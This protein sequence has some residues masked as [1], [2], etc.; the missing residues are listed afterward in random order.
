MGLPIN[1]YAF[2][3]SISKQKDQDWFNFGF[4]L[5][6]YLIHSPKLAPDFDEELQKSFHKLNLITGDDFLFT[7]FVDPPKAWLDWMDSKE[8]AKQHFTDK[9][10][11]GF[12]NKEQIKNPKLILKTLDTSLSALLIAEE[13]G[14]N[15][16]NLP[17]LI[18]TTHPKET[19][20]YLLHLKK[21]TL[22]FLM[23]DLTELAATI[24]LGVP[25]DAAILDL[26]IPLKKIVLGVPL[27]KKF[28]ALGLRLLSISRNRK[29]LN[30]L[31]VRFSEERINDSQLFLEDSMAQE[32]KLLFEGY[33]LVKNHL[34]SAVYKTN[35]IRAGATADFDDLLVA[36][37]FDFGQEEI[38]EFKKYTEA[39][40]FAFLVQ[41]AKLK[42]IYSDFF[43]DAGPFVL[44]FGKA[45]E[46][47][48]SYSLVHWIRKEYDIQLPRYFYEYQPNIEV[49]LGEAPGFDFNSLDLKSQEWRPPMLGGQMTGLVLTNRDKQTHPFVSDLDLQHFL[50][51]GFKLKNLRNNACHPNT[52][53]VE[54][55]QEIIQLWKTLFHKG[56]LKK[57]FE[58]KGSF[59]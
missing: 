34:H 22:L 43:G 2:F 48:M 40:T 15:T 57:L 31:R 11:S 50:D 3:E 37:C 46:L 32:M 6:G 36:N 33:E 49:I 35:E 19:H 10:E 26:G 54:N 18:L 42:L 24:K 30:A 23:A 5:Y 41:G 47:E 39:S 38:T 44:P 20:F 56:F 14:V 8:S 21:G 53:T 9:F 58:L 51:L 13:L 12:Y 17:F 25:L 27:A 1:H 4:T 45:F 59:R 29:S 55:L 52:S 28:H 7:S 16:N